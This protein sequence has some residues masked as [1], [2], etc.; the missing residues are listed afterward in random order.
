MRIGF[1]CKQA[2]ALGLLCWVMIWGQPTWTS[3]ELAFTPD[4]GTASNQRKQVTVLKSKK[5]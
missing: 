2:A 1:P 5:H 4:D 3:A